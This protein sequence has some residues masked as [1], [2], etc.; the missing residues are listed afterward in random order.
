MRNSTLIL[1]AAMAVLG[2]GWAQAQTG[3]SVIVN[4]APGAARP[5]RAPS[6]PPG[7]HRRGPPAQ[8]PGTPQ[9]T[10]FVLRQ[11]K[12]EGSSVPPALLAAVWRPWLGRTVDGAAL[13][14]LVD[15]VGEAED[16]GGIA[17]YNVV[18][19]DQDLSS[20]VVRLQ[21]VEG[22]IGSVELQGD[23][24]AR[25]GELVRAYGRRL[26]AEQ[27]LRKSTLQRYISLI[28]D[29]P[30]LNAELDLKPGA[31][32]AVQTLTATLKPRP[33]QFAV[34]VNNRGAAL[35]GRTQVEGDL[36]V[37]SL[38]RPGD[39]TRLA[40]AVP[41]DI[42]RFQY[43]ALSHVT[44]LNAEGTTAQVGLSYLR[45]R[46]QGT[47]LTGDAEALN[48]Q[49]SHPLIRAYVDNLYVTGSLDGLNSNNALLGRTIS[50]DRTRAARLGV[51]FSHETDRL[52]L[53]MGAT[54][55][56]GVDG[57][58]ARVSDPRLSK[59]DF[60]KLNLKLA[61]NLELVPHLILRLNGSAQLTGDRLPA[62]EQF[63]LG[64]EEFGRAYEAAALVG[65][66]G[67]AGSVELAWRP[68]K[69]LPAAL[70]GSEVYGFADA[71][72]VT[73]KSR[74]GLPPATQ[75]LSS[76]GGG[77]RLSL[78]S[79]ALVELEAAKAL[80]DLDPLTP[81]GRGWRGVFSIKTVY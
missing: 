80:A 51:A 12:V 4:R 5:S 17:L 9:I 22:R 65:D 72:Q 13:S 71:G 48:Q 55:S 40:V 16:R 24:A 14:R 36:F 60:R 1:A 59:V 15:A 81:G 43:Y 50:N 10:P 7:R 30:G 57:L 8:A 47:K 53:V 74:L 68:A 70:E 62:A 54:V 56:Q 78:G 44:P 61:V 42:Q 20:G 52:A 6:H 39:Q 66:K 45:T 64:G 19:P 11:V 3:S 31:D 63:A 29:I 2:P 49:L 32:P 33:V 35:L 28:R 23:V 69:L 46:P 67:Q 77:V 27:P 18:A 75:G 58:G 26:T 25:G 41:T 34:A 38:L 76:A 73:F 21:V 79:H 37:N